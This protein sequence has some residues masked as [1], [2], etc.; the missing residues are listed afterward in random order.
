VDRPTIRP[1]IKSKTSF[2][3]GVSYQQRGGSQNVL[4]FTNIVFPT[5]GANR[6]A[7]CGELKG[8]TRPM[9]DGANACVALDF[10][11]DIVGGDAL[12]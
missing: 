12:A 10:R 9:C 6:L 2:G 5:I 8:S 7:R 1:S 11:E 3:L 4:D